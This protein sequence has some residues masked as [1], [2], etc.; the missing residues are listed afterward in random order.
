METKLF[1]AFTFLLLGFIIGAFLSAYFI[2][3][4]FTK[5]DD[6]ELEPNDYIEVEELL[7]SEEILNQIP[8]SKLKK[9]L[10]K[11]FFDKPEYSDKQTFKKQLKIEMEKASDADDFDLAMHLRDTLQ[12]LDKWFDIRKQWFLYNIGNKLK[13]NKMNCDCPSCTNLIQHGTIVKNEEMAM[14]MFSDE[15]NRKLKKEGFTFILV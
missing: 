4:H 13:P 8:N 5:I 15:N 11:S 14:H 1:I 12:S 2:Y 3:K 9:F 7:N 6:E 10:R